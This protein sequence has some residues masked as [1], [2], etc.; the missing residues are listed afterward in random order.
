MFGL[1]KKRSIFGKFID[2]QRILQIEVEEET[3]LSNPIITKLCN[4]D[5]YVPSPKTQRVILRFVRGRG[6][7]NA[8]S[9]DL[10]PLDM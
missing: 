9:D 8:K 5:K 6:W 7:E 1:G 2:K 4:D 3:K 10:W